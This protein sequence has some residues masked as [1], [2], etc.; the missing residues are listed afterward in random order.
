MGLPNSDKEDWIGHLMVLLGVLPSFPIPIRKVGLYFSLVPM[1]PHNP[2][3]GVWIGQSSGVPWDFQIPIRKVGLG[4]S[5]FSWG[6]LPSFPI[7][8]RK[9]GLYLP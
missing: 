1:V 9:V 7:P 3:K 6:V 5:W 8:I 4:T 2:S